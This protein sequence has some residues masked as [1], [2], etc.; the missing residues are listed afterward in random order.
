ML[1]IVSSLAK[2][3]V[4]FGRILARAIRP[5]MIVLPFLVFVSVLGIYGQIDLG[6]TGLGYLLLLVVYG[7]VVL[8]NDLSDKTIDKVNRRKDIPLANGELTTQEVRAF[9]IFCTFTSLTLSVLLGWWIICW[10][11]A[12][13][14]LGWLYSGPAKLKNNGYVAPAIL[15]V[16]YGVMPWLLGAIMLGQI[17]DYILINV[18]AASFIFVTGIIGFKDFKDVKG[19]KRAKK[20]TFLVVYGPKVVRNIAIVAVIVAYAVLLLMNIQDMLMSLFLALMLIISVLILFRTD[21]LKLGR[22]RAM[23]VGGV[24]SLFYFSAICA[25]FTSR[26]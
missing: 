21:I 3:P 7:A 2:D 12:Y 17:P 15:G 24:R 23:W 22:A 18:M 1:A 11:L 10:T 6:R 16:C 25:L 5:Q 9:N 4:L 19:D 20:L 14:L 8:L 26:S 13:L